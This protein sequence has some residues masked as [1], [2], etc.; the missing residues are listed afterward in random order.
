MMVILVIFALVFSLLSLV[1]LLLA[2]DSDAR[3]CILRRR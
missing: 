2:G 1:P 3:A